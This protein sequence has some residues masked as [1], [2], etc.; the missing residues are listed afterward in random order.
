MNGVMLIGCTEDDGEMEVYFESDLAFLSQYGLPFHDVDGNRAICINGQFEGNI[1]DITASVNAPD[2]EQSEEDY[3]EGYSEEEE[4]PDESDVTEDFYAGYFED[5]PSDEEEEDESDLALG[6]DYDIDTDLGF[7]ETSILDSEEDDFTMDFDAADGDGTVAASLYVP[8]SDDDQLKVDYFWDWKNKGATVAVSDDEVEEDE[9]EKSATGDSTESRLYEY[10]TE[11]QRNY[12]QEYYLYISKRIFN[13]ERGVND[14]TVKR[15]TDLDGVRN[16]GGTWVYAGFIDMGYAGT[17]RCPF[18]KEIL[19]KTSLSTCHNAPIINIRGGKADKKGR[20][21]IRYAARTHNGLC[22]FPGCTSRCSVVTSTVGVRELDRSRQQG[23]ICQNCGH[24]IPQSSH[25]CTFNDPVRLMHIAWDISASDM[26]RNFYGQIVD[27]G[28]EKLINS[29]NCIK[30]GLGCVA[31]FFDISKTSE[32]FI[33]LKNV[34]NVCIKDMAQLE[35]EYKKGDTNRQYINNSFTFLDSIVDKLL[36]VAS[37]EALIKGDTTLPHKLFT[38]YKK[39]RAEDMIIPKSFIQFIRDLLLD[40]DNHKFVDGQSKGALGRIG[41]LYGSMRTTKQQAQVRERAELMLNGVV[42]N[43]KDDLYK[44]ILGDGV[45]DSYRLTEFKKFINSYVTAMFVYKIC[46]Y[47][48]YNALTQT[49]EGGRSNDESGSHAMSLRYF[50]REIE[51]RAPRDLEYTL[52]YFQG[53]IKLADKVVKLDKIL[54]EIQHSELAN[55]SVDGNNAYS[56]CDN[57][58]RDYV[59]FHKLKTL[60]DADALIQKH[61]DYLPEFQSKLEAARLAK[62]E[63]ERKWAEEREARLKAQSQPK[64]ELT[65]ED[66]VDYLKKADLTGQTGIGVAILQTVTSSG[67]EPTSRQFYHLRKLYEDLTGEDA[68]NVKVDEEA[69]PVSPNL[70]NMYQY[71]KN[72]SGLVDDFILQVCETVL[73]KGTASKKQMIYVNKLIEAYEKAK[74]GI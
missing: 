20:M 52:P 29:N 25:Y 70:E 18:C 3:Y 31:E 32:A 68:S 69:K 65:V 35:E 64:K 26:E 42:G 13:L 59:G 43:R 1:P 66:I 12:L 55:L 63:Q 48:A 23:V 17:S 33:A 7:D 2:E 56:I 71:V 51:R 5:E 38:L 36:L 19:S 67:K 8:S 44:W 72:H 50:Y 22:S 10:L 40:W 62:E 53:V 54:R 41:S 37:R 60:A 45:G 74:G 28:I 15:Q 21:K 27:D 58:M 14:L 9:V 4:V 24:V 47:Y 39:M 16:T 57:I 49:D 61:L 46:G 6:S 30:F 34:Q 11:S 73:K